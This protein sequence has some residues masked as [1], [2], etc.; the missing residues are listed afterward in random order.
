[1]SR[2]ADPTATR[3]VDLGECLCPGSPHDSDWAK[4]RGEASAS[5][6][7]KF[8]EMEEFDAD[9][10]VAEALAEFIPE[11]NL[12]GPN[13]EAWPPSRDSLMALKL[14]TVR[15]IVTELGKVIRESSELPNASGAPSAASTR[16]SAS[17]AQR[18][19]RKPTT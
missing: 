7:R 4:V 5:D 11:W 2:F 8:A 16:G 6:V 14:P 18:R 10:N 17:R 13:G 1:M 3:T 9:G 12:L 19:N 15:L